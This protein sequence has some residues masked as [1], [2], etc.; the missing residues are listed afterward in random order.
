MIFEENE[1]WDIVHST[2]T[3]LVVVPIDATYKAT[4]MKRDVKVRRIIFNAVKDHVIPHISTKNHAF[5]MW[6]VLAQST[7]VDQSLSF[8][9]QPGIIR[10]RSI[11][12]IYGLRT[13]LV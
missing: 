6:I 4:F 3:N 13:R 11:S 2:T 10:L 8:N 9:C 7:V 1:L 5:Q 12:K